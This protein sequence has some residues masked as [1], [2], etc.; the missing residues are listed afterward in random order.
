M[1]GLLRV[2]LAAA[3]AAAGTQ[4]H[5]AWY[6]ARSK[7]FIIDGDVDARTLADYAKK[8]ERFDQAVRM[9][10]GMADPPLTDAG[11]LT[12]YFLRNANEWDD[13]TGG[14]GILGGYIARASGAYAFVPK[15]SGDALGEFNSD[16]LFFHEYAHH[17]MFQNWAAALPTWFVEGFAEFLST[18][19]INDDGSVILGG[20]A[21]HRAFGV[22]A[23]SHDLPLT[24]MLRG[25]DKGLTGWKLEIIY[26]RGWLLMHYLTFEPSRRGQLDRYIAGIQNG[27]DAFESAKA[28]FGDLRQL[29]DELE[30]YSTSKEITG[31]VVR[32][33]PAKLGPISVRALSGG[34]AALMPIH[35]RSDYGVTLK[36]ARIVAGRARKLAEPYPSDAFAQATLAEAEY[37]ADHYSAAEAAAD[38]ALAADPDYVRA[39][40]YKGRAQMELAKTRP[41]ADWKQVRSWFA[42]ANRLDTENAEPLMLY[43]QSFVAAGER[44]PDIASKGL[45]YALVLAPQDH[46]LRWMA[47]RQLLLDRKLAEAK[48]ALVPIAYDPHAGGDRDRAD[49]VLTAI[50]AG[51]FAKGVTLIEA[52]QHEAEK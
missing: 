17:L 4:A 37:D 49:Q 48:H 15:M 25:T 14:G 22:H 33:D 30:R 31:V 40:I 11:R 23:L 20:A 21:N 8:L 6:E 18:A 29:D 13:L 7:H 19:K 12:I 38:R 2:A 45:L 36:F 35:V 32:P 28:A 46:K 44:P 34:E 27:Q 24:A 1:R 5:A 51:D 39:L 42:K 50:E 52:L 10:R 16:I 47:V 9:A 3:L 26:S 41:A 43:Y